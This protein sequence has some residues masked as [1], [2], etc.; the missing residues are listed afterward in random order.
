MN[1]KLYLFSDPKNDKYVVVGCSKNIK[2]TLQSINENDFKPSLF[3]LFAEYSCG[4]DI[5]QKEVWLIM[6]KWFPNERYVEVGID[7]GEIIRFYELSRE[8]AMESLTLLARLSNTRNQLIINKSFFEN[9]PE[10]IPYE[11]SM[12]DNSK[13]FEKFDDGFYQGIWPCFRFSD[14]N[15]KVG[16]TIEYKYRRS[17]KATVYDDR[18]VL[19][20]GEVLM[21]TTLARKI[22]GKDSKNGPRVFLYKG[23]TLASIKKDKQGNNA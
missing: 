4:E 7:T 15:I 17:I 18:H 19:Y 12:S 11:D 3:K 10:K 13:S 8:Q 6:E 22:S 16:E 9:D 5:T 2:K 21:L 23:R 1:N 14:C 20:N